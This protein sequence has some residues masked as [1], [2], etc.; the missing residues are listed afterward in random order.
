MIIDEAIRQPS[1]VSGSWLLNIWLYIFSIR[2]FEVRILLVLL[3]FY[4]YGYI[5][6]KCV[7]MGPFSLVIHE[8]LVAPFNGTNN[9]WFPLA[10]KW[11]T[12]KWT[13]IWIPYGKIEKKMS[14]LLQTGF[15]QKS[16]RSEHVS[17]RPLCYAAVNPCLQSEFSWRENPWNWSCNSA[18]LR[19]S[20]VTWM[21]RHY[22]FTVIFRWSTFSSTV[23]LCNINCVIFSDRHCSFGPP[24]VA[25]SIS[26]G[27][28]CRT[29]KIMKM[30]C[31]N[32]P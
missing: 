16:T 13:W 14:A 6:G 11:P 17:H 21:S 31:K 29:S 4:F 10:R 5:I 23:N 19:K 2:N 18:D 15:T 1:W 9:C 22:V 8:C 24:I 27:G 3:C 7:F 32:L 30:E 12:W 28:R 25:Q 26:C 20:T